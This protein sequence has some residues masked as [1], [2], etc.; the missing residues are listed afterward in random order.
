M[1]ATCFFRAANIRHK[2]ALSINS[3]APIRMF[4]LLVEFFSSTRQNRKII[5]LSSSVRKVHSPCVGEEF[6]V[7]TNV[8]KYVNLSLIKILPAISRIL[9]CCF[10]IQF[11]CQMAKLVRD[12]NSIIRAGIYLFCMACISLF[13]GILTPP[14][15]LLMPHISSYD[16]RRS[17]AILEAN[18]KHTTQ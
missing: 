9:K 11:P 5:A 1:D 8:T 2:F 7:I 16:N 14:S 6:S 3:R 15:S 13:A 17:R 4:T 10:A 12:T 18:P